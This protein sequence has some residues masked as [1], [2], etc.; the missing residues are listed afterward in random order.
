MAAAHRALEPDY[1]SSSSGVL[2][3]SEPG[4]SIQ[5][6]VAFSQLLYYKEFGKLILKSI[7]DI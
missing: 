7:P 1:S 3:D 6:Y 4:G 5:L 2:L